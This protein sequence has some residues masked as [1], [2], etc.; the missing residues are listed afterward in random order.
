MVG[1][2]TNVSIQ[3]RVATCLVAIIGCTAAVGPALDNF[4]EKNTCKTED[5]LTK[6]KTNQPLKSIN[7]NLGMY[8]ETELKETL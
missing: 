8:K 6:K 3:G 5:F 1:N 2:D 4:H 7:L